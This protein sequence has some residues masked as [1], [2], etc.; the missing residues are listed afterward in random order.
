MAAVEQRV[1]EYVFRYT[2]EGVD[3][4]KAKVDALGASLDKLTTS[5]DKSAASNDKGSA[6]SDRATRATAMREAAAAKAQRQLDQEA[7]ALAQ[8]QMAQDAA[9]VSAGGLTA[10]QERAASSA[11][12]VQKAANDNSAALGKQNSVYAEVG[13]AAAAHPIL[14]LAASVAAARALGGLTTSAAGYLGTA[15]AA[16]AAFAEGSTAMGGAVAAGG[17]LAARGLAVAGEAATVVAGGLAAYATKVE[18]ATSVVG[19]LVGALRLIPNALLPIAAAFAVFQVASAVIGKAYDDLQKLI[20]LGQKAQS[21]DV[22]APFLKSFESLGKVIGATTEQMD[23]ALSKASGFL[24]DSWGQ[25]NNNLSK[26]LNSITATGAAG[27]N[28]L[29]STALADTATTL[30][31]RLKAGLAAMKELDTLGLHLASIQVGEKVLGPETVERMRITGTSAEQ[32]S[33]ALQAA[34]EKEVLKQEQVDRALQLNKNISDTKQAIADAWAVNLDFSAAATLLDGIW[35]RILQTVLSIVLAINS[36]ID[37]VVAFGATITSAVGGAFSAV[38]G[39][40]SGVLAQL[41]IISK[42]AEQ[43]KQEVA[44]PPE[45]AGPAP[46]KITGRDLGYVSTVVDGRKFDKPAAAAKQAQQAAQEAVSSY[47]SLIQR[48][49]DRIEELDLETRSVGLNSD[50]V[51]KLKLAHDLERA[52]QKSG[53]EVTAEMRAEWDKLGTTLAAS[54]DALAHAKRGMEL[55]RDAQ[56]EMAEDFATF[57]DDVILGGQKIGDAFASLAKTFG[58]SSLKALLTGQGGLSGLFGT[59]GEKSGD[60]GGLLGGKISLGGL[61]DGDKITS[62]LGLGAESGIGKALSEA[63]KPQKAGGGIMSSQLGQG[64]A[65]V[66]AGASIGYSSQSPLM[67]AGG[68]LLAG[69]ASG[70]PILAVAG[71]GAGAIGS[72]PSSKKDRRH[73]ARQRLRDLA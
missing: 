60:L 40:I 56:R 25:N 39:Q 20:D 57:A 43:V 54:T 65:A 29:Q 2:T 23:Q 52:A 59:A 35:L 42:Q 10:A 19:L 9:A 41:G 69:L 63:L 18:G 3:Q 68:G 7:R 17:T 45:A 53:T 73:V 6:A 62:A 38:A 1:D 46:Q 34:A 26:M 33:A 66:G 24:K 72:I 12:A 8:V 67:G 27:A 61:F 47:D 70:N 58:S 13:K 64:F 15:S 37:G 36:A 21:L 51:I 22:G 48:T 14:V 4:T 28:G 30:E 49:K 31:E 50:A 55:T 32:L 5:Q 44:G 11:A 16:T 71:A